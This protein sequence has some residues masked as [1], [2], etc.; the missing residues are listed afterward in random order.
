M[1]EWL[2]V[3]MN[4][5]GKDDDSGLDGEVAAGCFY[6]DWLPVLNRQ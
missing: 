5:D 6:I 3:K 2:I 4:P 1:D